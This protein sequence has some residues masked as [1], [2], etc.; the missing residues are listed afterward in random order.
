[1]DFIS[2]LGLIIPLGLAG[3]LSTVPIAV[4]FVILLSSRARPNGVAYLIGWGASV[5]LVTLAVTT[6]LAFLPPSARTLDSPVIGVAEIVIGVLL[7]VYSVWRSRRPPRVH[8]RRG[9][10]TARLNH[11]PVWTA[12]AIGVALSLRPKALLLAA[13]V[14][15][16]ISGAGNRPPQSIALVLT[17]S[18]VVISSV[19]LPVVFSFADRDRTAAWLTAGR[20]YLG[21]H[22][23]AITLVAGLVVGTAIVGN[24]ISRL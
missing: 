17:Y 21:R 15:L 18:L 1:M 14:G 24:G 6:G 5:I 22:G 20:A 11:A 4:A 16:V 8:P 19:A 10:W 7:V 9:E 2:E 3:A 23:T 13:A 12:L